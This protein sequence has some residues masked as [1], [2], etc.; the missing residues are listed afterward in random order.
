MNNNLMNFRGERT[1]SE[2][3][4]QYEVTQQMWSLRERGKSFPKPDIMKKIASDAES[5]VD[6]IFFMQ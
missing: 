3:A 1:Q 2:M 4:K 5:T 6:A